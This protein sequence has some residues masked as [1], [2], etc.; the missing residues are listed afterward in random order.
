MLLFVGGG[1]NFHRNF[2]RRENG[3]AIKTN[4]ICKVYLLRQPVT[5]ASLPLKTHA[6]LTEV[7]CPKD[8]A[9]T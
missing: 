4:I 5:K 6:L 2:D 1:G 3:N 8:E 9:G 7:V